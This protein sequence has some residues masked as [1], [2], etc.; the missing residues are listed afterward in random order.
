MDMLPL[1]LLTL[2]A[3]VGAIAGV[4]V[5]LRSGADDRDA[6]ALGDGQEEGLLRVSAEIHTGW[7]QTLVA[8]VRELSLPRGA[9]DIAYGALYLEPRTEH[10]LFV[11]TRSEIGR[12]FLGAVDIRPGRGSTRVSYA[13]VRLPGDEQLHARVLDFELGL[14]SAIRR[15]DRDANVRL[16]ADALRELDRPR[17]AE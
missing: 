15:I 9:Q 13:I 11:R 5:A 3:V 8:L 1:I 17:R 2:V 14:I 12:G 4:V 7:E 16:A 6:P 10:R